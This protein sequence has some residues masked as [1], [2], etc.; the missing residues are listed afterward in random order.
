[1]SAELES[2][3]AATAADLQDAIL[4]KYASDQSHLVLFDVPDNVGTQSKRRCDAIAIGNWGSTG[5]RVHG[6]EIKVSRG[7]WLRELKDVSKADPFIE[8][9]NRWWL[10]TA[11][12]KLAK[13]E[14]I[15]ALWGWMTYTKTGL[16]TQKMATELPQ[17]E[18][19]M[20]KLFALGLI[21]KAYDRGTVDIMT[22][23]LVVRE[24]DRLRDQHRQYVKDEIARGLQAVQRDLL[25]YKRQAEE[26]EKNSGMRLTDW[27]LGNVGKLA[28]A[29][30]NLHKEGYGSMRASLQMQA[31]KL[32]E[33]SELIE[34]ALNAMPADGLTD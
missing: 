31:G 18:H 13:L 14:E 23:P 30:A 6:F 26:F 19:T 33:T 29:I 21:R 24:L 25:E 12:D 9:C 3:K 32:K 7:D 15:P 28:R 2:P 1:V 5:R 22:N 16:R 8:R 17:P 27:K 10:V 20:H 4:S 34:D 11:D